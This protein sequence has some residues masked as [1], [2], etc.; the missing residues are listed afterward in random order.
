MPLSC[1]HLG[2]QLWQRMLGRRGLRRPTEMLLKRLRNPMRRAIDQDRLPTH[3]NDYEIQGQR[4]WC[5]GQSTFHPAMPTGR[6]SFR[7]RPMRSCHSRL[8]VRFQRW[9]R[10]GR[11]SG[12]SRSSTSMPHSKKLP[13]I[14]WMRRTR[15]LCSR[16]PTGHFRLPDLRLSRSLR[17]CRMPFRSGRVSSRPGQLHSCSMPTS[18][19]LPSQTGQSLHSRPT[20]QR[21]VQ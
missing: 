7:A 4:E 10:T 1:A 12:P 11:H 19:R 16:T 21:G 15:L 6:R 3:A 2:R 5:A 8:L 17:R 20:S 18:A 13:S 9:Q 14:D